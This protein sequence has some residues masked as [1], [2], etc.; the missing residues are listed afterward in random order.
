MAENMLENPFSRVMYV[1][2][3]PVGSACNLACEYCYYLEKGKVLGSQTPK[4]FMSEATLEEYIKQYMAAQTTPEVCFTWHG[5]EATIRPLA[6]YRK[7]V[8]LQK[9]Y[10]RGRTVVNSLQTNATL[11][12]DEW[13]LFLKEND[14]LVGVSI[15]GP[16]EFHDEYRRTSGDKP[17][18]RNVMR[19]IRLLQRHGVEWNALAVV[20]DYNAD[21]PVEFYRF[22]KEIG[23]R[24]IQFT[25]IVERR[26]PDGTLASVEEEGEL[27]HHSITPGQWG[28]FLCGVFDEWVKE[29][30]G[31]VF[32]QIFDAT[33]AG[34][35]GVQ[36]GLCTMAETCGHAGMMEHNGDVY[37]CD[38]F[39][40]PHHK[41]GN[42][43]TSSLL[44]MMGS[45]RQLLFGE[46]K[47]DALTASCRQCSYLKACHGECPKNRFAVDPLDGKR[48][49]NYLC[50]GYRAYFRHVA[51]YMGFMAAEYRAGRAPAR[52]MTHFRPD[53]AV[54][55]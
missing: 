11:L 46:A 21:Y 16:Q 30:V 25:P 2:A 49:L 32:V 4:Q 54:T 10:A 12:T 53:G 20:N 52:V 19:G 36:P 15:D 29:D 7:V 1:M 51:P 27:T 9:R 50:G 42:I 35:V 40:F 43:H 47:R 39:A 22:F 28:A 45:E 5:G 26:K 24:F 34:W 8:E 23:C 6:F 55:E 48:G 31:R 41:L 44:E 37:Q 13:C 33:L 38:H 18:F 14:W 3:K 17:T